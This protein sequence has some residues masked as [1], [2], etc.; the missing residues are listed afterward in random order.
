MDDSLDSIDV[1]LTGLERQVLGQYSAAGKDTQSRYVRLAAAQAKS[2]L[3]ALKPMYQKLLGGSRGGRLELVSERHDELRLRMMY[4]NDLIRR[5]IPVDYMNRAFAAFNV[6][7]RH[8]R[9][10]QPR[11]DKRTSE[12]ESKGFMQNLFTGKRTNPGAARQPTEAASATRTASAPPQDDDTQ[13]SVETKQVI[14]LHHMMETDPMQL[15]KPEQ[16]IK[17][18]RQPPFVLRLVSTFVGR[19]VGEAHFAQGKDWNMMKARSPEELRRK[20][21]QRQTTRVEEP[22]AD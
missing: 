1:A 11:T 14:L 12:R 18:T 2:L 22:D 9:P 17:P 13:H 19:D 3:E 5:D 20:L 4:I 15:V 10:A 8:R 7:E 6:V 21:A 16:K